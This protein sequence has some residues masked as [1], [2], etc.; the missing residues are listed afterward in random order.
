PVVISEIMYNPQSGDQR[1]EYIELHNFGST[2]VTLYDSNEGLAWQFTDGVEYVFPDDPGLTI[3][4]GGYVLIVKN[5]TAYVNEYGMPPL[6]VTILG[7]YN[8]SLSNSGEKLELSRP[9][10]VDMYG[11]RYYIRVDRVNYS[12]GSHPGDSPGDVDLWPTESDAGGKSLTRNVM[13]Q[14]GNDPNN[15]IAAAPSPGS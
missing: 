4:A 11:Q 6:G 8:G 10:D 3:P 13:S 1:Q 2:D 12:D 9:G 14:Y 5:L 7:P 15:W